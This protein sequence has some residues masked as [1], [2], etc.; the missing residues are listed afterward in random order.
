[1]HYLTTQEVARY[2]QVSS[3][4]VGKWIDAGHLR[5]HRT[6]GGHRRVARDDLVAFMRSREIPLPADLLA[7]GHPITVLI[8]DGEPTFRGEVARRVASR[9]P[10]SRIEEAGSG[11]EALVKVGQLK[12]ALVIFDLG[13]ADVNVEEVCWRLP[14]LAGFDPTWIVAV[15]RRS[16]STGT[17]PSGAAALVSR[18]VGPEAVVAAASHALQSLT[19]ATPLG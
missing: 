2:C 7:A 12:P 18:S 8:A 9:F 6:P 19:G 15:S 3:V 5:G 13:L 1:M 4:T 16:A 10:S 17:P 14:A 11:T